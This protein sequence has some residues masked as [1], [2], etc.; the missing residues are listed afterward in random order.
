M[1][2]PFGGKGQGEWSEV[3]LTMVFAA[4]MILVAAQI[5]KILEDTVA[6]LTLAS[7]EATARDLGGAI[8]VSAAATDSAYVRYESDIASIV[9][10]VSI[11]GREVS[12]TDMRTTDDEHISK[13]GSTIRTGLAKLAVDAEGDF[14]SV[15]IFGIE[16]SR[17]ANACDGQTACDAFSVTAWKDE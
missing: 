9:Y 6:L 4:G 16:K 11:A 1:A 2:R 17:D 3:L 5:P 8:T 12:I 15:R 14:T 13:I 10:D 7:A